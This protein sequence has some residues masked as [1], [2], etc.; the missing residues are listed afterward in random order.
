MNVSTMRIIDSWV[1]VTLSCILSGVARV[2]RPLRRVPTGKPNRI[3]FVKLA[4][5]G[6]T[7]LAYPAIERAVEMVGRENVYF[8]VFEENRFILD[9]LGLIPRENVIV[10]KTESLVGTFLSALGSVWRMHRIKLDAAIDMEFF[11]RASAI[12]TYLSGASR[13]VGLHSYAGDGPYRGN[14]MTH[15]LIYNPHLHTCQTFQV[16]VEALVQPKD[17]LPAMGVV[18]PDYEGTAVPMLSFPE[19]EVAEMERKLCELSGRDQVPPIVLLNANCSDMIVQRKW[20][21]ENYLELARRLVDKYPDLYIGL[22]GAPSEQSAVD[23]LVRQ[24]GSDRCFGLAGHTTLKQLLV[25]YSMSQI[26]ITN[27]SGPAHFASLTPIETITLFGPETPKL[28][29]APTPR[30]HVMW[31]GLVCSPCV[32]AY[33]NRLTTCRRNLCMEMISVDMVLTKASE[34]YERRRERGL[35]PASAVVGQ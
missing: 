21:T 22:T 18:A 11:A 19:A 17:A 20:E 3:L 2:T 33:N 4:E 27:D 16:M 5:Q 32:N 34:I 7:V 31:A 14:L 6:S 23:G 24:V 26:L 25:V 15:P 35:H 8:L 30:S 28:F 13:R 29:K 1:G 10:I 9:A 12:F